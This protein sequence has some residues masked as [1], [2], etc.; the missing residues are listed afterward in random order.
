MIM[1]IIDDVAGVPGVPGYTVTQLREP[2]HAFA[3]VIPVLNEDRRLTAQLERIR[4]ST[5]D[6]DVIIADG[7]ST[8]GSTQAETLSQRGVTTLLTKTGPGRLSA[9][10]RMAIHHCLKEGYQAVI[11]MDGNGKDGVSGI[12]DIA[13]A[14]S[15]G[16]DFVQGS[17]FVHGGQAVNTPYSRYLA[18][19]FIHAPITSLGARHWYT[20]TTNGFRGLKRGLLE[21][22]QV[23]VLREVFDSYE[24]LAY[25]PIRAAR[26]GYNVTEVPVTRAYP[27]GEAAPT[28]IHGASA[29][30]RMLRILIDASAGRFNPS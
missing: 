23:G 10:L 8:D 12:A 25:L 16:Y 30:A 19:R 14:L 7:G 22:P 6:V 20:D 27:E 28:K 11:T 17:R 15:S 1:A 3:L 9:Q 13:A 4:G 29:H 24:L 18:I 21:D 26:L 5:L 2:L